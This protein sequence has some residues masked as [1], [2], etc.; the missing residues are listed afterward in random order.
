M[1]THNKT[2]IL[3]LMLTLFPLLGCQQ[4]KKAVEQDKPEITFIELGAEMCIPCQ[5]MQLVMDSIR[6]NYNSRV[7]VIFYDVWTK[8]GKPF[9]Y[10][11]HINLIPTQV[12]KDKNGKEF[13]RHVGYFPFRE[14]KK[15]LAQKGVK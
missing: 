13:Y 5:K 1:K 9:A 15:I 11:Y 6:K 7:K 10:Q 8:E 3:L 14:V 4:H 2:R 12:F